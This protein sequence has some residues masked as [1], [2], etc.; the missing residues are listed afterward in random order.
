[1][2]A[3]SRDLIVHLARLAKLDLSED[4]IATY[5]RELTAIVGFIDQLRQADVGDLPPT[6]QVTGLQDATREDEADERLVLRSE[7]LAAN[8]TLV[9]GQL[10]VPRVNL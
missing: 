9:D 8:A 6:E 5:Q 4:E 1:M 7:D 2:S 3:I 10:K